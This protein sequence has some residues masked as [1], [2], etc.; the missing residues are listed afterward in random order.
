MAYTSSAA[1]KAATV[2]AQRAYVTVAAS[3]AGVDGAGVPRSGR[4][5]FVALYRCYNRDQPGPLPAAAPATWRVKRAVAADASA[6]VEC[7]NAA[8]AIGPDD[9]DYA[10]NAS[11]GRTDQA[12]IAACLADASC[13][14][15][16][17]CVV[18]VAPSNS[19]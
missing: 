2:A 4:E 16:P 10:S 7:I 8:F 18:A 11:E 13:R 6:I 17:D 9:F 5:A 3:A 12:E 14:A 15:S 19:V 1:A